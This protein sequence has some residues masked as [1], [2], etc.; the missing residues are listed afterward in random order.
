LKAGFVNGQSERLDN[1]KLATKIHTQRL[2]IVSRGDEFLFMI[3][4][5][6]LQQKQ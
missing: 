4:D 2:G 1:R 6:G 5:R 3:M